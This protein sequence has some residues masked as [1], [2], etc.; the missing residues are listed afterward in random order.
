[1]ERKRKWLKINEKFSTEDEWLKI[2]YN[3]IAELQKTGLN[4]KKEYKN[5][6]RKEG[7]FKRE[8]LEVNEDE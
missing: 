8:H 2:Y 1:M 3:F 7:K 4:Y 6:F 5:D